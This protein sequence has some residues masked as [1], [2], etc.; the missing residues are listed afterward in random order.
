MASDISTFFA[1]S[2]PVDHDL[3]TRHGDGGRMRG[4]GSRHWLSPELVL[5]STAALGS[6]PLSPS[7]VDVEAELTFWHGHHRRTGAWHRDVLPFNEYVPAFTLG[8]SLFLQ[9]HDCLLEAFDMQVMAVRYS[10]VRR[11]S[12]VEWHEARQAVNA[13]YLRLQAHWESTAAVRLADA[14]IDAP[15]ALLALRSGLGESGRRGMAY[16]RPPRG[17]RPAK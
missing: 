6:S 1:P 7:V 2:P 3:G 13:A 16:G 9:C 8:I 10:R 12:R 14:E 5:Q 4:A 17:R 11:A 15:P